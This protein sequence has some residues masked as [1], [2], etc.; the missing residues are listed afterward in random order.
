MKAML[1]KVAAFALLGF[2]AS[3]IELPPTMPPAAIV[4]ED[5]VALDRTSLEI[6]ALP[7]VQRL[8]GSLRALYLADPQAATPDGRARLD[9]ALSSI[10]FASITETVD[11]DPDRPKILWAT[12]APHEWGGLKVP[13]SGHGI[14]NP[15]NFYRNI[16]IDGTARY[17][18]TGKIR[19]DG[20]LQESFLLYRTRPGSGGTEKQAVFEG[21]PILGALTAKDLVVSADGTFT[22]T[23]DND[24]AGGGSNHIHSGDN[25]DEVLIIRDTLSD[26]A[27]QRPIPL[28]VRRV[29]GPPPKPERT[30]ADIAAR[31]L[32]LAR[33]MAPFWLEFD[34]D[35][36]YNK[37]ANTIDTPHNRDG[38]WG[39]SV[40]ARF[41]LASDEALVVT[42]DPA[43]AR[44]LGF[45]I[46]D[47]WSVA[48]D[49]IW[50]S[51]SLNNHQAVPD[52]DG[53]YTYVLCPN[54]PGYRN[55]IDTVGMHA[56]L[57]ALRWQDLTSQAASPDKAIRAVRVVKLQDLKDVLPAEAEFVTP[58]ERGL[59]L[60]E[61][62]RTY[63]LRLQ[64]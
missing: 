25:A 22:I 6:L 19:P 37:P 1:A 18:I 24:P 41:A 15:D 45:Q 4:G 31:S 35:Y 11:S 59:Q 27:T 42:L 36:V 13:G 8:R 34:N 39:F 9:A 57:V 33:S 58:K 43:G 30:P 32:A 21:A 47:P 44:Y 29:A 7:E 14:D 5:Q 20:P 56:G 51:S 60:S 28:S 16:P 48:P 64:E 49:Y 38:G 40:M 62:A 61:R 50:H 10:L 12:N 26:L 2:D 3:A 52:R 54:D 53:A 23:I 17:E 46:A 63:A 55:W